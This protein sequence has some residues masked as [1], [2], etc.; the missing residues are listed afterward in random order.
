M[1]EKKERKRTSEISGIFCEGK[2][3]S[4]HISFMLFNIALNFYLADEPWSALSMFG[5]SS[6]RAPSTC[7]LKSP[8]EAMG[9]KPFE[10]KKKRNENN[11]KTQKF[12]TLTASI[13]CVFNI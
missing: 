11:L 4:E 13:K 2:K 3:Y 6:V 12:S 1:C 8:G 7:I 5:F 9:P 10:K